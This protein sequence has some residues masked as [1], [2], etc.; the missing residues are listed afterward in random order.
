[1]KKNLATAVAV[2]LALSLVSCVSGKRSGTYNAGSYV[3]TAGGRNGDVTVNVTVSES[4]ITNVEVTDHS[5]SAGIADPAIEQIPSAI[6]KAQSTDVDAV[7]GATITSNAIKEAVSI[8]LG[9]AR[10]STNKKEKINTT[11]DVIVIGAGA[12]GLAAGASAHE[13]GASVIILETNNYAGGAAISSM[14]NLL[15]IDDRLNS[16]LPRNDEELEKY[17]SYDANQFPGKWRDDYNK[18]MRQIAEYKNNGKPNGK[19]DSVERVMVDHYVRGYGT[20]IDGIAVSLDYD[21]IRD[22]VVHS[23]E[24]ADWLEASG[25]TWNPQLPGPR[26]THART[27]ANRGSTLIETLLK[28]A[29]GCQITYNTRA[30][31]LITDKS[32]NVTGVVATSHDGSQIKFTAKKGVVI[33]TGGFMGNTEMMERYR[34]LKPGETPA[35]ITTPPSLQGDGII[36]AE[37]LGAAIRDMQFIVHLTLGGLIVDNDFHVLNTSGKAIPRLFAAGDVTSGFEGVVHQSGNCMSIVV[38]GGIV[39]GQNAAK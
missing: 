1:M 37:K 28:K 6:V 36:M 21:I 32:G 27:P 22:A 20:D 39:A 14:G 2:I 15:Y 29:E 30:T 33:A 24:V 18:L 10:G 3:G 5:E 9:K 11:A 8:A 4:T 34:K 38:R 25:F 26:A 7:A 12:A 17:S 35:K 13:A 19:F 23:T 31:E 16:T